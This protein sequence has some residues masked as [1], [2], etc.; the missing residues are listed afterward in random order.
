MGYTLI[1]AGLTGVPVVSYDYDFHAEIVVD[2]EMGFLVPLRDV[3]ALAD[4]VCRLL[5]DPAAARAMGA[6]L[7]QRL[8]REHSLAA[9]VPQ[10][11]RA[12]ARVLGA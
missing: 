12:Y 7:R 5:A 8:L 2:G 4:R 9:V 6:R 3:R 10:Y 11:Q 1:E